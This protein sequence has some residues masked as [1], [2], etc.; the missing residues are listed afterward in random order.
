MN[1]VNQTKTI[2]ARAPL[3]TYNKVVEISTLNA[4]LNTSISEI[5]LVV[6][7]QF[8]LNW[9]QTKNEALRGLI[10]KRRKQI[11]TCENTIQKNNI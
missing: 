5:L 7:E 1:N 9:N 2:G 11:E 4:D 10:I 6:M 3:E 8:L